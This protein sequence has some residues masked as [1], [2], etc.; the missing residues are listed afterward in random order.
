[1][2]ITR[3][4][5]LLAIGGRALAQQ[6][7]TFSSDVQVVSLL[8]NVRDHDGAVVKSLTKDDFVLLEDGVPQ[9]IRYFAQESDLRLTV[10]LLVDTSRSQTGVLDQERRASAAFL[11]QVLRE[12][13]DQGCVVHFDK[14]V[15]TLQG[16]TSS[17]ANLEAALERLHVPGEYA[18]LVFSAVRDTSENLMRQQTGRKALI[19]LTD[20][21]AYKDPVSIGTAIE[22][23]QRADTILYAIRMA[24][25][26]AAYRPVR[27]LMLK[28][29]SAKGKSGLQ[30]M[31]KETG[32]G[33]YEVDKTHS[34]ESIYSRIEESL[35][36]QYSI[37]YTPQ[38]PGRDGKFRKIKLTVK[39]R[40]LVVETRDGYYSR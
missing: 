25:H 29:A 33:M 7:A 32:G 10:G 16:L 6:G 11:R 22:F 4:S 13:K 9:T 34:I 23:A 2:R 12:D 17:R 37:G 28:E 36:N 14:R 35:R 15:E 30:R 21:V 27:A 39:G 8:A 18:T 20:G 38:K 5:L 31:A 1:M 40:G 19:L 26:I 3:R 24:D